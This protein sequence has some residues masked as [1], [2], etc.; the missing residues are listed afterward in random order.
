[1]NCYEVDYICSQFLGRGF[2]LRGYAADQLPVRKM[3][4]AYNEFFVVNILTSRNRP[5]MMGQF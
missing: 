1:M 2:V 5:S 4:G 3:H